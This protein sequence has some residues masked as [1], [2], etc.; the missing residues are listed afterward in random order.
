MWIEV[1]S[2]G[3]EKAWLSERLHQISQEDCLGRFKPFLN[4]LCRRSLQHFSQSGNDDPVKRNA[5][6][7]LVIFV[8]CLLAKQMSGW[9]I[10]DVFAGGVVESDTLFAVRIF[11]SEVYSENS[12]FMY[13]RT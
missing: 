10:M 5:L 11:S 7:T 12:S 13:G 8:R 9:E 6:E 4:L 3:V 2:L 1:F